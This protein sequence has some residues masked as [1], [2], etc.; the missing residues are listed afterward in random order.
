MKG[1]RV[2]AGWAMLGFDFGRTVLRP[3]RL[4][5]GPIVLRSP[6]PGDHAEWIAL[7]RASRAHLTRWE[8]DWRDEDATLEA[9]RTRLRSYERL[10]RLRMGVS[11][12]VRLK[13]T[14]ALV[15]GAGLT[16]IRYFASSSAAIGYWI[17]EPYL[18]QGL[19]LAAAEA[20]LSHAFGRLQL[21]RVEA[22]CQ[23]GNLA[24]RALLARAGF[25]EEGFARDYLFIN[26]AWRDHLLFA[27]TARDYSGEPA[28]PLG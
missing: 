3:T 15:G 25:R 21:N 4:D 27:R 14:G 24:S 1:E 12:L 6:E 8:P 5:Y 23:P 13:A 16:E 7:R 22:A 19:G 20:L 28:Q 10:R 18:R 9:W 17:G 2:R 26:G 11:L